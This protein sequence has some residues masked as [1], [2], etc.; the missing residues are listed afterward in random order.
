MNWLEALKA[1]NSKKGGKYTIPKK[2]SAEYDEVKKLMY[3]KEEVDAAT[4]SGVATRD[5]L[6]G[7]AAERAEA[8][9]TARASAGAASSSSD[10]S[11][12]EEDGKEMYKVKITKGEESPI[13]LVRET[14]GNA[15][16][17]KQAEKLIKQIKK[18][19]KKN[20]RGY[21]RLFD[22]DVSLIIFKSDEAPKLTSPVELHLNE[23]K[24]TKEG[25]PYT[26]GIKL[27]K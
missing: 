6:A 4:R 23:K 20:V 13:Q 8:R 16:L 19:L 14:K 10:S 9:A 21:V 11:S 15:I 22:D 25:G 24:E 12:D 26:L 2:G 18:D 5:V 3:G 7:K 17:K 1:W 27:E